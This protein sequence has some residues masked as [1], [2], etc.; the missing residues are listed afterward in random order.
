MVN[1]RNPDFAYIKQKKLIEFFGDYWHKGQNPQKRINIFKRVG[2]SC[3]VI[4]GKEFK[5]IKKLKNKI[6]KF[7]EK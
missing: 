3:V 5:N 4:W 2:W 7:M 1:G 6:I